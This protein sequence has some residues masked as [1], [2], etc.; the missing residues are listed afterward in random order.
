MIFSSFF[1]AVG[2]MGD[3]RFRRVLF[4]GVI[5]TIA[6]LAGFYALF[7][8]LMNEAVDGSLVLPVIGEVTWIGDLLG[9]GS[10]FLMLFLSIFLMVPVASAITSLFLDEVASAVEAKHYPTLPSV[11]PTPFYESLR[12][13]LNFLGILIGANLVAFLIYA[14]LPFAAI[15][16]FWGLNGFLLGREYFQIAAMRRLGRAGA[17]QA[18]KE[19]FGLIWLAGCL[20]ALPL[21]V[22]LLN[23][24]IPIL[25][26]ATFT[27]LF[28]EI[29]K[30]RPSGQTNPDRAR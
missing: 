14:I 23:L 19:N 16:I 6:L 4:L 8:T 28:H 10:L 18:R 22:P 9:W 12:D 29:E 13:T 2:Q 5:L 7:L 27:H 15:F 21:T 11:T 25:G 26:A 17:K 1:K 30:R 3:P 24:F 20:M